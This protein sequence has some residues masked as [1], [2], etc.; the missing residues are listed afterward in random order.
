[1]AKAKVGDGVY[2]RDDRPGWWLS[3]IEAHGKR[4]R[5]K[6]GAQTRI[7]A[8]TFLNMVKTQEEKART[9]GVRPVSDITLTSLFDRFKRHQ[10]THLRPTTYERLGGI[11]ATLETGLPA[12]AKE[13]TKRT[14]A[15][16]IDK[17]SESV[18]PGN[19][20]PENQHP[21]ALPSPCRGM[22]PPK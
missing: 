20:S 14:V 13:I 8:L 22:E 5:R 3:H 2:Q 4:I 11:L 1:M 10:K 21:Q 15:D 7:Q 9:L 19:P 17:R 12:Q 18:S 16:Y 6:C